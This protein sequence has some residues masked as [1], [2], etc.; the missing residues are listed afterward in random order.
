M[1]PNNSWRNDCA[2]ISHSTVGG[3][4]VFFLMRMMMMLILDHNNPSLMLHKVVLCF[5]HSRSEF[6][7]CSINDFGFSFSHNGESCRYAKI[8]H[9]AR[10]QIS[11]FFSRV[12]DAKP[13]EI[14]SYFERGHIWTK[15][16]DLNQLDNKLSAKS[17]TF[18]Q[19]VKL[20]SFFPH[21]MGCT[22][23]LSTVMEANM[24]RDI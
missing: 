10:P 13:F 15:D 20:L 16:D 14:C 7:S 17:R 23:G 18:L 5:N 8:S 1:T 24:T 19:L 3:K 4:V 9:V 12:A 11:M 6:E 22:V 2:H 21:L